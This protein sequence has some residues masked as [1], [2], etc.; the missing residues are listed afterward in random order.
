[1]VGPVASVEDVPLA[2][3][4]RQDYVAAEGA[5]RR[6]G[7]ELDSHRPPG[8]DGGWHW[9][10][11]SAQEPRP[12]TEGIHHLLFDAAIKV[13]DT[14]S[15]SLELTLCV[16]WGMSLPNLIVTAAV[17]VACWC[18]HHHGIH[19]VRGNLWDVRDSAEL[20]DAFAA[21][22]VLLTD[23]LATGPFEPGSWRIDAGLPDAPSN[24]VST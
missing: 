11:R 17:E 23:V 15:D 2:E 5:I 13:Y 3:V 8:D 18:S 16:A 20:I 24:A 12:S 1:M 22:A 6:L 7:I 21:G 10:P 9:Y 19:Q 14:G 4:L